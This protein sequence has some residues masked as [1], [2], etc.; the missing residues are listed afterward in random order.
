MKLDHTIFRVD[1]RS[2]VLCIE[3]E[4]NTVFDGAM[5]RHCPSCGSSTCYPLS[6]WLDRA[7]AATAA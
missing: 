4:C 3:L 1:L 5:S 7:T 6:I 2:A